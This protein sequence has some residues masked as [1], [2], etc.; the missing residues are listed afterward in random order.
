MRSF[1]AGCVL[2]VSAVTSAEPPP[3]IFTLGVLRRDAIVVPFATYDGK[4]WEHHWPE[5][6]AQVEVPISLRS[7]SKRWWGPTGPLDIWQTWAGTKPPSLVH[8]RQPDWLQAEC[9]KQVGLRTDYQPDQRPPGPE[10]QP[11]P[12]DGLAVSPAHVVEPLETVTSSSPESEWL[13][14]VLRPLFAAQ[15]DSALTRARLEGS[16]VHVTRKQLDE[17]PITLEAVYAFGTTRRVYWVEAV[18][19]YKKGDM[20]AAVVFG[21]GWLIR[22]AGKLTLAQFDV[23]LAPC[24]RNGL[25]YML[26]LGVLSLPRGLYWIAQWSGW[27]HENYGIVEIRA[28]S[29]TPVL[30]VSGGS[31]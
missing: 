13:P 3:T 14:D 11:Y 18:R 28:R 22:E 24:N 26:P 30:V 23:A 5:P 29:I 25:S 31:C 17:L 2:V 20:C 7:V 9:D 15:E 16:E 21:S 27:D 1:L 4:Q 12:K 6:S 19:E 10:T 8:V